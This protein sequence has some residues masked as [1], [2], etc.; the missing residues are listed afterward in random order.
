[1]GWNDHL[2]D[3]ELGNPPPK[4]GATSSTWT[5][6]STQTIFGSRTLARMSSDAR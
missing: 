2:D 6:R 5:A 4:L 3:C 1:M